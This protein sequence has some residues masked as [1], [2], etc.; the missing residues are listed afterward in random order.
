MY[1]SY[2]QDMLWNMKQKRIN[3]NKIIK[4]IKL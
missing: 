3:R 2:Q 4:N 1:E